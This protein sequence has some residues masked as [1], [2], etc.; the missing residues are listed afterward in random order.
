MF[1]L[2]N[3]AL[4]SWKSKIWKTEHR[5]SENKKS[6][7]KT[8]SRR[9][10]IGSETT[11]GSSQAASENPGLFHFNH[12][13]VHQRNRWGKGLYDC[14]NQ[15][16]QVVAGTDTVNGDSC[17]IAADF[18]VTNLLMRAGNDLCFQFFCFRTGF[19]LARG[20]RRLFNDR[21]QALAET[22]QDSCFFCKGTTRLL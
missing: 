8:V 6:D 10:F 4:K 14:G 11:W 9:F 7:V 2:E 3:S 12:H 17:M 21:F 13:P 1:P 5:S 20:R 16:F 18:D 19:P 22:I 15:L